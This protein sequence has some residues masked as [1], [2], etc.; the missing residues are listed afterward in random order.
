[1]AIKNEIEVSIRPDGSVSFEVKCAKGPS[2]FE[3]TRKLE[4]QLGEVI[5]R[6]R[7]PEFYQEE[8]QEQDQIRMGS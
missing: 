8:V 4:E 5:E 3:L 7:T 2:C 6:E 1:M